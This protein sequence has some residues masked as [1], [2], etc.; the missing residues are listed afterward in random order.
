MCVLA[1]R[2]LM[3]LERALLARAEATRAQERRK[4]RW[5]GLGA[6]QAAQLVSAGSPVASSELRTVTA[7]VEALAAKR[8]VHGNPTYALHE[9]SM[10]APCKPHAS[11]KV[12]AWLSESASVHFA[13]F[14]RSH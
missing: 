12:Q 5:L 8:E 9:V 1:A 3:P 2:R 4:L 11:A 13:A 14:T 10:Q 6:A 7:A